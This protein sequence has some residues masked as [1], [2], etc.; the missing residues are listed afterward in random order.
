MFCGSKLANVNTIFLNIC[1]TGVEDNRI[2][3]NAEHNFMAFAEDLTLI[4]NISRE[5]TICQKL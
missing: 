5:L 2:V 1:D 3:F 4:T